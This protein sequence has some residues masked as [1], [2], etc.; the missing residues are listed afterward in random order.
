MYHEFSQREL[1]LLHGGEAAFLAEENI[2][3]S[4]SAQRE[5]ELLHETGSRFF[6]PALYYYR[7]RI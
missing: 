4:R 7:E 3:L 6:L 5:E 2:R 1:L